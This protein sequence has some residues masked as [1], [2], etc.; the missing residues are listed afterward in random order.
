[1][2]V[3]MGR[4][5]FDSVGKPLPGRTN[6]VITQNK[7]W[8]HPGVW[9]A[10]SLQ[11]AIDMAATLKTQEIFITGGGQ[12]YR[13]ALPFAGR[14]Y[15]TRVHTSIADTDTWFPVLEEKQW[16]LK[17]SRPFDADD[18]HAFAYQ[19]ECWERVAAF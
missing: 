7:D 19:F 16:Q 6:I 10:D 9:V 17:W 12:I 8:Q 14:V 3:I 1:M 4:K 5:T 15:L 11:L 18:K 13:E 2:P